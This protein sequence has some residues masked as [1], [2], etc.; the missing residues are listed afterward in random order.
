MR[1]E[2]A[3]RPM[4]FTYAI[5]L[6]GALAAVPAVHAQDKQ[7]QRAVPRSEPASPPP[8]PPAP[9]RAQQAAPPPSSRAEWP[10]S[11]GVDR[12]PA[13]DR[14]VPRTAPANRSGDTAASR[15][16]M[17]APAPASESAAA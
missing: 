16:V 15:P 3:M 12:S 11:R 8:P 9:A 13:P 2:P 5:V 7:T 17:R 10:P 4:K 1:M 6:A 14:A